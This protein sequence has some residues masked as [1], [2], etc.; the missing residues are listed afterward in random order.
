M[1][2]IKNLIHKY[3]VWENDNKKSRKTALDGISLDI[4]SGQF[5]AI[6]GP[7]GSGKST[8]AKHLNV[9]LLPDEGAVWIDGKNT[10]DREM[11]WEIRSAVGMV[12]QNPENQM[13]GTSVEEDVAFGPENKNLPSEMIRKTVADSLGAVGLLHRRK[14]SPSRLSGGE[15]QRAAI[16]GVLAGN[17]GFIVL[18]EPTA[19]LDP[20]SRKEVLSVIHRLNKES[21]ITI[22]LITHHTDEVVQADTVILMDKGHI[23]RQG[24]P[25]TIF[26]DLELLRQVKMDVPQVTELAY[27]LKKQGVPLELPILTEDQLAEEIKRVY[28]KSLEAESFGKELLKTE[29]KEPSEKEPSENEPSEN[30]IPQE[31]ERRILLKGENLQFTYGRGTA[32][33]IKVLDGISFE[34]QESDFIGLIGTSGSGKTTLMKHLNGLLKADSGKIYFEGKSIYDK[35]YSLTGLRKEVGLVFQYPEHQLFGKNVL[36]D[37]MFGPLNLGMTREEAEASAKES[38]NLVG[39]DESYYFVSPFELSGGQ[40]RCVAIA[41][42]LAM[43]PQILVMD[44]PAAGLDPETKHKIFELLEKIKKERNLAIVLVSHHMEDVADYADKV[45]VLHNGT[46]LLTGS[47]REIFTQTGLLREIGIGVPQIT[48]VTEKLMQQGF[49]IKSPAVTVDEAEKIFTEVYL[50]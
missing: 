43:N 19:M 47:P 8:L 3:T 5:I 4:P 40:K 6:L 27:R 22:V 15:K 16:A 42:V 48:S 39:I 49:P 24:T 10:M 12:F 33:E 20:N 21:G 45:W 44:E 36:T 30:G 23:I 32:G 17:P 41:G 35:K 31:E 46:F 2:N 38:L 7:N 37:V 14:S 13:I 26:A 34:I 1:I 9:L 28:S 11:L 29:E 50:K 18:D 25:K